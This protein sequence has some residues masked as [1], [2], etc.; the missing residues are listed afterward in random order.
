MLNAS[1][2][3]VLSTGLS[4]YGEMQV[5]ERAPAVREGLQDLFGDEEFNRAITYGPNDA[6]KV[7]YRFATMERLLEEIIGDPRA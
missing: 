2:W 1:L 3:D 5:A 4:R 7:R 6:R